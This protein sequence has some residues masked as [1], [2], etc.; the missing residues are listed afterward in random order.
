MYFQKICIPGSTRNLATTVF[1]ALQ[2]AFAGFVL[3]S[4][5]EPHL[6]VHSMVVLLAPYT[7]QFVSQE[8]MVNKGWGRQYDA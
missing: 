7:S 4:G 6:F 5:T 8:S 3:N 1:Q 2:S